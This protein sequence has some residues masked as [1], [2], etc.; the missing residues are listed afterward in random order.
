MLAGTERC[1]LIDYDAEIAPNTWMPAPRSESIFDGLAWQARLSGDDLVG[2]CFRS[3]T[4]EIRV[5]DRS[6]ASLGTVQL[7]SRRFAAGRG[8]LAAGSRAVWIPPGTHEAA[9]LVTRG[10]L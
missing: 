6:R 2:E 8:K 3:S 9:L 10:S 1:V 7:P 4:D 5:R